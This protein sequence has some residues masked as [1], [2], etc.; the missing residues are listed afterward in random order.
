MDTLVA[1]E[2]PERVVFHHHLAGPA[3]RAVAWSIDLLFQGVVALGGLLIF[4]VLNWVGGDL[5]RGLGMGFG[6][7]LLFL[8]QW[9]YGVAWEGAWRGQTP[10]KALV[11]LRVVRADGG[12]IG[13]REAWLRNL[14]RGADALPGFYAVGI[15]CMVVEPRMRR[16]GDLVA[17][18]MV[19]L[20]RRRGGVAG[21]PA[22]ASPTEEE[23]AGLPTRVRLGRQER[24]LLDALWLR[25]GRLGHARVAEL[26]ERW[27]PSLS[28]RTGVV[29]R[30]PRRTLEL[31]W[32][33]D[34]AGSGRDG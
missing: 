16:L 30:S 3:P 1:I 33:L 28:A 24:R 11:G 27:A 4:G 19:V 5:G 17:G 21:V 31:C 29:G 13:W 12:A 32:W 25:A 14:M 22:P 6:L 2:T 34:R 10:G 23:L 9:L 20:E 7:V 26:A 8:L 15:A 18:T